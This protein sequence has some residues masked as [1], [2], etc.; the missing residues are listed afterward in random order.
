MTLWDRLGTT[1]GA[2]R[3]RNESP[4]PNRTALSCCEE[5]ARSLTDQTGDQSKVQAGT[6]AKPV[7]RAKAGACCRTSPGSSI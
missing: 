3:H 2:V 7:E 5:K 6:S 1:L 4:K